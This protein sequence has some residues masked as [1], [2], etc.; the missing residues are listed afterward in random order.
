MKLLLCV[1]EGLGNIIETLP[2]AKVLKHNN[3]GFDVV[4]V[5]HTSTATVKWLYSEYANVIT[6]IDP[7]QYGG[8]IELATS[9]GSLFFSERVDIPVVNDTNKQVVYTAESNEI[10]VYLRVAKDL[11]LTFS[12]NPYDVLLPQ[13]PEAKSYDFIVHNGCS[14]ENTSQWQRKKYPF[15]SDLIKHL[16]EQGYAVA[17]IGHPKEYC[18]GIQLTGLDIQSSAAYINACKFFISNDTGTFHLAAA[19][20]NPGAVLFTATS[21]IKNYHP[22]FHRSIKLITAG[23]DCQPCQYK[24]AWNQCGEHSFN[25]WKCRDIPIERILKEIRNAEV[26]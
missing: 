24:D 26:F 12:N 1:G 5:G 2:L 13:H 25:N 6:K 18:G 14:L 10:E 21:T 22:T 19:M 9:K 11:G 23:V 7:S 17:S 20:Q 15:M 16:E 4:N 8:R 3:I